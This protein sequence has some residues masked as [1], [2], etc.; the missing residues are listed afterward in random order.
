[1]KKVNLALLGHHTALPPGDASAASSQRAS[2]G[3]SP[4]CAHI[5][6]E[7]KRELGL[8][9]YGDLPAEGEIEELLETGFT[10]GSVGC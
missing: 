9:G 5:L 4:A 10:A 2:R 7:L 6:Q 1:M 8:D 3:V